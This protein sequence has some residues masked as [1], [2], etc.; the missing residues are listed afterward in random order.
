MDDELRRCFFHSAEMSTVEFTASLESSRTEFA[1]RISTIYGSVFDQLLLEEA[2]DND[3][4]E[5]VI[6]KEERC[7][8][9]RRPRIKL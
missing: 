7:P 3:A 2:D 5:E 9:K 6:M 8:C 4:E 1:L